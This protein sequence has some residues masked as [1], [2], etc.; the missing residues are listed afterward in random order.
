[1]KTI[2]AATASSK[3]NDVRPKKTKTVDVEESTKGVKT[4]PKTKRRKTRKSQT[5]LVSQEDKEV[6]QPLSSRTQK[7]TKVKSSFSQ[8]PVTA[9]VHSSLGSFDFVSQPPL[10]P[11]GRTRSKQKTSRESVE[12]EKGKTSF[13]LL[14][15]SLVHI[16]AVTSSLLT[17]DCFLCSPNT[18]LISRRAKA[19]LLVMTWYVFSLF[20][21]LRLFWYCVVCI[22]SLSSLSIASPFPFFFF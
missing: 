15:F 9:S 14:S 22:T 17:S 11:S 18:S 4:D 16:V 1:M 7:K 10:G 8:V 19:N 6:K 21:F 12:R 20:M 2:G 3:G 5:H 13:F